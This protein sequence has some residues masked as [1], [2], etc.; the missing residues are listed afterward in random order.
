M[1]D[2][3][4]HKLAEKNKNLINMVI[5]RAKRDFPE[6]IALIGLSGSFSTDDYHEKSDLDLIIVNNTARGWEIGAGFIF[7][8]VGYD[9]YCTPWDNL[10]KKANLNCVAVSSLTDLQI[11]YCAKPEYLERFNGLK[12]KALE[13]LAEGISKESIERA[14]NHIGEA[15]QNHADMVLSNEIGTVRYASS[16]LL[17]NVINGIVSLNNTCIKRGVKRYLEELSTYRYLPKD[18]KSLYMS[19]IDAKTIDDIRKASA[20]L[21]SATMTLRDTLHEQY[22]Q[23][24]TPTYENLKGWYEECWCNLRNKMIMAVAQKDKSYTFLVANSAQSYF[25]E[26]TER[27]GTKKYNLMQHFDSDNLEKVRD[28]FMLIM[29]K[30]LLVYKNAGRTP[31]FYDTFEALY[32]SYMSDASIL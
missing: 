20:A 12:E 2:A 6:D 32:D 24:P 16:G 1:T 4:R 7:D 31:A 28:A 25:D 11:L 22:V 30:Y 26:M 23:K 5:A 18:F 9:I 29:E 3:I 13:K 19:I 27:L 10:E 8:D 17:Y 15:K 14:D 21:L